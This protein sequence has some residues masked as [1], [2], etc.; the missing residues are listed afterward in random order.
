MTNN[1]TPE[2]EMLFADLLI[3][4]RNLELDISQVEQD[5]ADVWY[6]PRTSDS[7]LLA[8]FN[9]PGNELT[10]DL[11]RGADFFVRCLQWFQSIAN[12]RVDDE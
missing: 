7:W 10:G 2:Q 11:D 3:R 9:M 1:L 6:K 5:N 12:G 4:F 8:D